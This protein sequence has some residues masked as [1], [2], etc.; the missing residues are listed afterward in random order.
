MRRIGSINCIEVPAKLTKGQDEIDGLV[1]LFH[2]YGADAY[3]LQTLSDV[4][5]MPKPADFLF[6]QGPLEVPVGP[7]WTGRAWWQIDMEAMQKAAASGNPRDPAKE[8]PEGL[9]KLRPQVLQMIEKTGTPWDRIVLGGFSQGAMLATDLFL[10]APVAPRSL[11]IFSGALICQDEWK[12]LAPKRKGHT[13][14]QSH[15]K[16]DTVLAYKG[17]QQLETLLTQAG[18]KGR[19]QGFSGAHEI[20][21]QTLQQATEYL[22]TV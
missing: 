12:E 17:A 9:K 18:M 15:G 4:L 5:T 22:R 3:D 20:P 7:G 1:I 8:Y 13:F 6:P 2:G 21:L 10:H 16:N 11:L 19:L 14:F